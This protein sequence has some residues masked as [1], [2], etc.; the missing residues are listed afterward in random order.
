MFLGDGQDISGTRPPPGNV[1]DSFPYFNCMY[2][3]EKNP[4]KN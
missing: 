1:Y 4:E 2:I 3:S